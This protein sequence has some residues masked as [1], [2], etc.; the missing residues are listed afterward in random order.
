MLLL[1]TPVIIPLCYSQD[2]QPE[3]PPDRFIGA[4]KL[5]QEKSHRSDI[6]ELMTIESQGSSYKFVVDG[7]ADN[8]TRVELLVRDEDARR[9]CLSYS[10]GWKADE[11]CKP[12]D[13]S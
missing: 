8:G 3:T 10:N 12:Y 2:K 7:S 13:P 1:A 11:R 5:N 6:N 4:W 9:G